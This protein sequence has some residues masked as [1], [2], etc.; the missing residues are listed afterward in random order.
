MPTSTFYSLWC[1]YFSWG[2]FVRTLNGAPLL[3]QFPHLLSQ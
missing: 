3:N 1:R 2:W